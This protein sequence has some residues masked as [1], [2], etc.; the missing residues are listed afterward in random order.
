MHVR[1]LGWLPITRCLPCWSEAAL[2]LK[3][4]AAYRMLLCMLPAIQSQKAALW[5][6]CEAGLLLKWAVLCRSVHTQAGTPASY[7]H[8]L[9][10]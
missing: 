8:R 6:N 1:H 5:L 3:C 10:H 2:W 4:E 9:W 7:T